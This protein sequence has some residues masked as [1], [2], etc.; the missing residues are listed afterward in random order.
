MGTLYTAYLYVSHLCMQ[1]VKVYRPK[2]LDR[3]KK[4]ERQEIRE[5]RKIRNEKSD[6]KSK[7]RNISIYQV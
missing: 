4:T 1:S 3:D 5:I 7:H 2:Y 6:K